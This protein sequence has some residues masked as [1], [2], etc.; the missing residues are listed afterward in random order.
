M[1][2]TFLYLFIN[3][4]TINLRMLRGVILIMCVNPN[5]YEVS[6]NIATKVKVNPWM[7]STLKKKN[8]IE[9]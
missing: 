5:N 6:D 9:A 4:V 7:L 8:P 3:I 2:E 1:N